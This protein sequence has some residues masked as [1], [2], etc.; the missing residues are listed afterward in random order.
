M[1]EWNLVTLSIDKV[2]MKFEVPLKHCQW[3]NETKVTSYRHCQ[4][5][6]EI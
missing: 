2:W 6:N 3:L 5:L 1:F 4:S